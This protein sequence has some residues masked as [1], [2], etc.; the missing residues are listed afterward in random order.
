MSALGLRGPGSE[1]AN[2]LVP[3]N[4]GNDENFEDFA[5]LIDEEQ[6]KRLF[7]ELASDREA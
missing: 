5:F 3:E 1:H 2:A 6:R 4:V 7:K